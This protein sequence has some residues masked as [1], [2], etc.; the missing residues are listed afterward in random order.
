[1]PGKKPKKQKALTVAGD[2]APP[3]LSAPIYTDGSGEKS[4]HRRKVVAAIGAAAVALLFGGGLAAWLALFQDPPPAPAVVDPNCP[5]KEVES[6]ICL[7]G[8]GQAVADLQRALWELGYS[9]GR[10]GIDGRFGEATEAAVRCFQEDAG[11]THDGRAGP[12]TL[13]RIEDVKSQA[14]TTISRNVYCRPGG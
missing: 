2:A 8:E 3:D 11:I 12:R 6:E 4:S 9:I 14:A 10:T 7:G 1:M 5:D 13:S